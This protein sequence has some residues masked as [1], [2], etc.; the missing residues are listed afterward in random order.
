MGI[1][2]K[3]PETFAAALALAWDGES[4][5]TL[6]WYRRILVDDYCTLCAAFEP[7]PVCRCCWQRF[8]KIAARE[9]LAVDPFAYDAPLDG[10]IAAWKYRA[11]VT[12]LPILRLAMQD[13][14]EQVTEDVTAI[15]P[16]PLHPLKRY[17]RGFNQSQFLARFAQQ[18]RSVPVRCAWLRKVR[19]TRPQVGLV[20]SQRQSNQRGAFDAQRAVRGERI[21]LIDDVMTTGATLRS[22]RAALHAAGAHEVLCVALSATRASDPSRS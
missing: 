1:S 19:R 3:C 7:Y 22:A 16:V 14:V 12:A 6:P 15:C 4:M 8:S 13:I 18:V 5:S 11:D 2:T 17:Q 21:L 9:P 20:E 10:L